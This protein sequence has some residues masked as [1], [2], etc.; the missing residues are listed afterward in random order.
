MVQAS[1]GDSEVER[2]LVHVNGIL[3]EDES[4]KG[5][6]P[7]TADRFVQQ[8]QDGVV[9]WYYPSLSLLSCE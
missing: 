1:L 4:L 6:L 8:C 3:V 9:F 5:R 7:L 2:L